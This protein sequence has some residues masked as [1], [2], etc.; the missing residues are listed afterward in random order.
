MENGNEKACTSK[1]S[2]KEVQN[3]QLSMRHFF[4]NHPHAEV[5][6]AFWELYKGWVY[7]SADYAGK[8]EITDMLIFYE[9]MGR[10]VAEVYT[11]CQHLE[12]T[13]LQSVLETG[14]R[15]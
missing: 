1:L 9:A 7:H 12:Q 3:L 2:E 13:S 8:E 6:I 11:Y 4:V 5:K 14:H 10:F 15:I